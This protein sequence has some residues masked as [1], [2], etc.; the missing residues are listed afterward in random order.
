MK[1]ERWQQIKQIYQEA[2]DSEPSRREA[3]LKEACTGDEGLRKEV[4]SLLACQPEAMNFMESPAMELAAKALA[5]DQMNVSSIELAGRTLAH[6]RLVEKIGAGGMGVVYKAHDT[7]LDRSVA[8]KVLPAE[9]VADPERKRRFVQEARSASALNH[10]GIVTIHDVNQSDGIDFIAMEYITGK[11]LNQ[12]IRRK[13]V[14]IGEVLKYAV[15]IADALAAA[16]AAGI[17]HRDLKPANIMVTEKGLVKVLDFGLAKL[18]ESA[19]VDRAGTTQSLEP[20]TEEGTIVGTVAYMSPEQGE[21]KKVDARS[22]I[23]S[24]GSVLYEMITGRRA[25]QGDSKIATLSAILHKETGALSDETPYDLEKIVTRCL[26]K[27][28]ER[29]FQHM[30]DVKVALEELKEDSESG[31]LRAPKPPRPSIFPW[32]IP[33]LVVLLLGVAG[34]TWWLM[35]PSG[36]APAPPA[37]VLTRLTSDSGLTTDPALSPDGKLLAYASDRSGDGNLDIYVKQVGGGEPLRL[38]RDSADEHEPAFSPDGTKIAFRSEQDEG[39][40]Y[41]VSALGG[42]A[43]MIAPK[44]WQPQFSPDGRWIA[45]S[46]SGEYCYGPPGPGNICR[47]YVVPPGGGEP[48]QLRSDFATA[49]DPVWAPDGKHLLFLGNREEEVARQGEEGIDWWVTP[50]DPGPA[51]RTGALEATRIANLRGP[52][53]VYFWLLYSPAWE[54]GGEALIFSARSGD[55]TNLW[56]IGISPKTWKV[57][58]SPQRLTAETTGEAAPSVASATGSMVRLAFASMSGNINIWS[59]PIN[60]NQGKVT[61]ELKRV[62]QDT[63]FNGGPNLSPDGKKMVWASARS[64]NSEIWIR[65]L[66]TG[67]ES[68]LTASGTDKFEPRFSPDGSRVSFCSC[69]NKRL[70]KWTVYIIPATGGAPEKVCEDCGQATGWSPDGRWIIGNRLEGQAWVFDVASRHKRDLLATRQWTATGDVSPDNRWFSFGTS[71]QSYIAPF[72]GDGP[73]GESSW[74]DVLDGT[75]GGGLWSPDGKLLYALSGR[76]GFACIWAQRLDAATKRPFGAPFAVFHSHNAHTAL[77]NQVNWQIVSNQ[78]LLTMTERTGN[79]WMAEFNR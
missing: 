2:L 4:E 65:D 61:G 67:E 46:T 40:I 64:G 63:A 27:D 28:P 25:F 8:I 9:A 66:R 75:T 49:T 20:M 26:R 73:I 24:F 7:H 30:G 23:F 10:P 52:E 50:L 1:Q 35:R 21:G 19:P 34:L 76:D 11:T 54:P 42:P 36:T 70:D 74:I 13:G 12:L 38:T 16:H 56:R 58:G 68:A 72:H 62:T 39:G 5:Q 55:S 29:R 18:T 59:L 3:F 17:I 37:P 51:I 31:K 78:L 60:P 44:G 6:Y 71:F 47:I 33:A 22:D 53:A 79:I 14:P 69:E 41:V 48:R 77:A 15:Q 45:Y 32:A 57:T 43:R